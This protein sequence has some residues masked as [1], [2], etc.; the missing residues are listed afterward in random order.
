MLDFI[1]LCKE[2]NIP[3]LESGHHHCHEG[4]I[5]T[6]CPFCADGTHGWHLGFGIEKGNMNCWRCG[7]HP[8][9]KF[10]S[11][12]LQNRGISVKQ[13]LKLYGK[14]RTVIPK[15]EAKPRRRKTKQPPNMGLFSNSHFS[16]LIQRRFNPPKLRREWNLKG[17]KGISSEWSWRIIAPI[18]NESELIV[19]YAGRSLNPKAKPKWKFSHKEEMSDDP[20]K[21]IYGIEKAQ[22]RVLIVEGISDVWRMGV[23]AVA[24]LGIDWK[25]EQ[26]FILKNFSH[27]FIM[28][29]P[30]IQA[31]KKAK[32]LADWLA[33]FPGETEIISGL[34]SDPGDLDQDEAN[35]YMKE[36]GF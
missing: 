3:Y 17:T 5:Q 8:I 31:Q 29:D 11:T 23:G 20:K 35:R 22:D 28:F 27:R 21:M 19:S 1:T 18:F 12:V 9:Y 16:Y 33:P 2:F 6:H 7:S 15:K 32:E 13:I 26:A 34:P 25:I 14:D 4:W 36:L 30:E 10:L 24:L